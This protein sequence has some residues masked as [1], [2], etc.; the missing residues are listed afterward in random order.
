MNNRINIPVFEIEFVDGGQT[1]WIQNNQGGTAM[2]IKC[3]GKIITDKCLT[4]PQ[5]H[6]DI[7]I[8]G[9]IDFCLSEDI[10]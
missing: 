5:S 10:I 2:R 1:I 9:N 4:S 6:C 3:T 8:Q 7:V